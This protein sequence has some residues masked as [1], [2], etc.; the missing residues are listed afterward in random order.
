MKSDELIGPDLDYYAAMAVGHQPQMTPQGCTIFDSQP[1]PADPTSKWISFQ[2]SSNW[3][4]GGPIIERER[5][6]LEPGG[7]NGGWC[8][9]I[10]MREAIRW[11]YIEGPT[12][13][14]A[15]MRALVFRKFG[16]EFPNDGVIWQHPNHFSKIE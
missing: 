10:W 7:E 3:A 8:A 11:K 13:L 5:I 12:P 9:H 14:V 2:P 1:A 15:A 16:A 4:H 6:I